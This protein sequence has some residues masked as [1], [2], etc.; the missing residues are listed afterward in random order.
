MANGMPSG[1]GGQYPAPTCID[2]RK[3]ARMACASG[4]RMI[5]L[6]SLF[7]ALPSP[8][9]AD[10]AKSCL[11]KREAGSSLWELPANEDVRASAQD[12]DRSK[13]RPLAI[14]VK[15]KH[16]P[17][18]S[19]AGI[20]RPFSRTSGGTLPGRDFRPPDSFGIELG[21]IWTTQCH[22]LEPSQNSQRGQASGVT[23]NTSPGIRSEDPPEDRAP[24][25]A[26]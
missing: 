2:G 22:F 1:A 15:P 21:N 6:E 10:R 25:S 18:I 11:E 20:P 9:S 23:I 8:A 26:G 24:K 12:R 14:Q 3:I 19:T 4:R 16:P 17:L 13:I 7:D 5:N